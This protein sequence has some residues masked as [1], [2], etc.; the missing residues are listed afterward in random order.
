MWLLIQM[1]ECNDLGLVTEKFRD[2]CTYIHW[3]IPLSHLISIP[4]LTKSCTMKRK[5]SMMFKSKLMNSAEEEILRAST[6]FEL[7]FRDIA[8]SVC[9]RMDERR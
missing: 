8:D 4:R 7:L 5:R 3:H 2:I 9:K 1:A 6:P